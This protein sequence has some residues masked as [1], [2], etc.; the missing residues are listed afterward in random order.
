M[1]EQAPEE[2]ADSKRR[3]STLELFFGLV[4][5]FM[6]TQLTSL[7]E[8][9]PT[10]ETAGQVL[11]IFVVLF[12]MYGGYAWLTNQVP[13]ENTHRRLLLIA[14]MAGFMV[15]ALAAP[16]AFGDAGLAIGLGYLMVV[17]VHAGL[18]AE[19]AG[20]EVIRFAPFNLLGAAALIA[21]SFVD[22]GF[23][24]GLWLVPLERSISLPPWAG[25]PS[26]S[27]ATSSTVFTWSNVTVCSSSSHWENR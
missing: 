13:P 27:P 9:N 23:R 4:F 3:V 26:R 11:L 14:A 16:G 12:W 6:L 7:L 2:S 22:G 19:S 8:S 15:C 1:T 21:A 20:R 17:L 24:Y 10:W 25:R 5:V 18:Y